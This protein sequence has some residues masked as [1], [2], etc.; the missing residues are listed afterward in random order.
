[1]TE[2]EMINLA[3]VKS[4]FF[5]EDVKK[6]LQMPKSNDTEKLKTYKAMVD[7]QKKYKI[8]S[9][10]NMPTWS[11]IMAVRFGFATGLI[12]EH[13]KEQHPNLIF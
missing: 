3:N 6:V 11:A 12:A 13:I 1:M 10:K 2:A 9:G 7:I 5:D 4:P 8:V